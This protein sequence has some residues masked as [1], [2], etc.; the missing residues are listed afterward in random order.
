M[1][2]DAGNWVARVPS[3]TACICA[4]HAVGAPDFQQR[5]T[6]DRGVSELPEGFGPLG[7]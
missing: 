5:A 6:A 7:I 4:R 2:L 3:E 1:R